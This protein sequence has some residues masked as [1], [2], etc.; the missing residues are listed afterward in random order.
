MSRRGWGKRLAKGGGK[1]RRVCGWWKGRTEKDRQMGSLRY[2]QVK[3]TMARFATSCRTKGASK[4]VDMT[5]SPCP[6]EFPASSIDNLQA[7]VQRSGQDWKRTYW[8]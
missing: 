1:G 4:R 5:E 6:S 2:A 8:G 3:Q 7:L